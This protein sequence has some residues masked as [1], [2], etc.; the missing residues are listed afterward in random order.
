MESKI[1]LEG[2]AIN[3]EDQGGGVSRQ[4]LGYDDQLMMV[5]VKFAKGSEG[6][7]H[8]HHHSQTTYVVSGKFEFRVGEEKKTISQGDAVYI[9]PGV[10]HSALC[11][12]EGILIDAFSPLREDFLK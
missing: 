2:D 7:A 10:V 3:W 5:K 4:I 9:S 6:S 11:I 8:S 12:D 1:F